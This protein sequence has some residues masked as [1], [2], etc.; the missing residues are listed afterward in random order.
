MGGDQDK[1]SV[2][3][4]VNTDNIAKLNSEKLI[5]KAKGKIPP[6]IGD[7]VTKMMAQN[8]IIQE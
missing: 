8:N 4:P 1:K 7:V 2:T 6:K 5:E 3:D